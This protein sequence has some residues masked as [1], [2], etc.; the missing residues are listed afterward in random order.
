MRKGMNASMIP[1]TLKTASLV[2]EEEK[3]WMK[4]NRKKRELKSQDGPG[5][6]ESSEQTG[7]LQREWE[8]LNCQDAGLNQKYLIL[9]ML[10]FSH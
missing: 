5:M 1:P 2:L 6:M 10:T 3:L 7:I 8:E 4:Q 9:M